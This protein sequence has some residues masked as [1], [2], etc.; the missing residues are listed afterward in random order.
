MH[1][2]VGFLIALVLACD[3]AVLGVRLLD[4]HTDVFAPAGEA[5]GPVEV[6]IVPG[7]DQAFLAGTVEQLVG[8]P[9]RSGPL[10]TPVV[11]VSAE[12]G[13]GRATIEEALVGGQRVTISWDGGVALPVSGGGGIELGSTRV[14]V[15]RDGITWTIDG[16]PRTFLPGT[17]RL[18]AP[19]ALAA[20]GLATPREG[21]E[22][23]ADDRTVLNARGPVVVRTEPQSLELLG[24]GRLEVEGSLQVE[25]PDSRRPATR[26]TF[27][28]GP[29]RV[30]LEPTPSGYRLD[31]IVEGPL[32]VS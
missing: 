15:R 32:R 5:A 21:V 12:R 23:T 11:L 29:F 31:G 13:Q 30:N 28:S 27:G 16:A 4:R 17:Y 25:L 24:P 26:L 2:I 18:G 14:E 10:P 3:V 22:F 8:D 1:R 9:A 7:P 19:V 20:A 6:R